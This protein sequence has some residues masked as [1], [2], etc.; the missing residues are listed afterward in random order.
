M[1][2]WNTPADADGY[3]RRKDN[4]EK[5]TAEIPCRRG[6]C[7]RI[8]GGLQ[9][10][11]R[12]NG[13]ELTAHM[14]EYIQAG[15]TPALRASTMQVATRRERRGSLKKIVSMLGHVRDAE[16]AYMFRIPQNLEG[17]PAHEAAESAV[18]M[19]DEAISLLEEAFG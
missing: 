1:P 4:A 6:A 10:S 3:R 11:Q 5:Q 18:C 17:A 8:Q 14:A 15:K 16:E 12:F 19:I 13:G 7:V 9:K 2:A